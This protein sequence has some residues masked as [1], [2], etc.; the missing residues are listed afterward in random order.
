MST[1]TLESKIAAR[2]AECQ[3]IRVWALSDQ[4][5]GYCGSPDSDTSAGAVF[6]DA[7]RSNVIERWESHAPECPYLV[8]DA[9]CECSTIDDAVS[10]IADGAPDVYTATRWA[11]FVDLAAYSEEPEITDTWP[12]SLTDAAGQALYQIAERLARALFQWLGDLTDYDC[13]GHESLAAEH[14]GESVYCDG[15][16]QVAAL[17]A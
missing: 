17:T 11:E 1:T 10:E 6:L 4:D 14:M 13:E 8:D 5:M 2:V 15:M 7:V 16:C 12:E 3:A 9:A